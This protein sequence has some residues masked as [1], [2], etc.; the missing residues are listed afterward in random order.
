[1]ESVQKPSQ[2]PEIC[3]GLPQTIEEFETLVEEF[4]DRLIR[5]A[6]YRLGNI[7]DAEDVVQDVF[8]KAYTNRE[9][10]K[11]ICGIA[12]YLYRMAANACIDLLRKRKHIEV[13]LEE[14]N[15][16]HIPTNQM[17]ASELAS[18]SEEHQR[19]EELLRRLPQNQAEVVRLRVYDELHF[20]EIA[21]MLQSSTSTVK[22]QFL[23]GLQKLRKIMKR[24]RRT[25]Q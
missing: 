14:V 8:V 5:Y 19:I 15:A 23:Y 4:Q 24:E 7:N 18:A 16:E 12:P 9:K 2:S 1:M 11:K 20:D 17:N 22:S 3:V 25:S 21:D 13:S 10:Y 6:F